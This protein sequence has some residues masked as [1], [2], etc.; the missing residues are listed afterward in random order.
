MAAAAAAAIAALDESG[1]DFSPKL[2]E[3]AEVKKADSPTRRART[4][5]VE[6]VIDSVIESVSESSA[7]RPAR[8]R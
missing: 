1:A 4:Q 7:D 2:A 3:Q 5:P 8:R 6:A